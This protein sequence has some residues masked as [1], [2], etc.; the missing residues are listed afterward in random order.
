MRYTTVGYSDVGLKRKENQDAVFW[1]KTQDSVI[2]V[3]ADGMGG[4]EDGDVASGLIKDTVSG[5]WNAFVENPSRGDFE[6]WTESLS[7]SIQNANRNHVES[8]NGHMSGSTFDILF[9]VQ[10]Q[11][12]ILHVGDSRVY[13][14][15]HLSV[16]QITV[17]QTWENLPNLSA[18]ER[19]NEKDPRRGKLVN[20]FGGEKELKIARYN[21]SF[22]VGDLYFL[23]TDGVYKMCRPEVLE[24]E[25][26]NASAM[27]NEMKSALITLKTEIEANGARDNFSM[28]MLKID[29]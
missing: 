24:R 4:H 12:V 26:K 1:N 2:C 19:Q 3:I 10:K 22:S 14:K 5:W 15:R 21:G 23:C 28:I 25:I 29:R 18:Q 6:W 9:G 17:D 16:K 7:R 11:Y 13:R 20:A 8:R 27:E